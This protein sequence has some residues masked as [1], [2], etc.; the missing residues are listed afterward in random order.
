MNPVNPALTTRTDVP[1][2]SAQLLAQASTLPTATLHEA[3]KKIGAL[4]SAIKPVSSAF[5]TCGQ[6]LTVHSP[7]ALT[8]TV[9][10]ARSWAPWRRRGAWPGW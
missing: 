6:A 8:S 1:R 9:I 2:L 3:G 4:P 7:T 5:K 10:G